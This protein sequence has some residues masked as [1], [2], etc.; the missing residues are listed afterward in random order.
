MKNNLLTAQK[1]GGQRNPKKADSVSDSVTDILSK[2][3][4]KTPTIEIFLAY[5]KTIEIYKPELDYAIKSK[6]EAWKDNGW[7]DGNGKE[8]KNWKTTLR[9]TMPYLKPIEQPKEETD[10]EYKIRKLRERGFAV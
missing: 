1:E 2:D 6:Y 9:N 7:K 4:N 8:I 10:R 3:N 5:S